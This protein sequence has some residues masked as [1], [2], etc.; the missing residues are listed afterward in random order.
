M[1]TTTILR[2]AR[3]RNEASTG[4]ADLAKQRAKPVCE[5]PG[6]LIDIQSPYFVSFI[7]LSSAL[8]EMM[9]GYP[10]SEEVAITNG[11]WRLIEENN[12]PFSVAKVF[13]DEKRASSRRRYYTN[14]LILDSVV[15]ECAM[16][17]KNRLRREPLYGR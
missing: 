11:I 2:E 16:E 4:I 5:Q 13:A 1:G 7:V 14:R 8:K 17:T 3:D 6:S 12:I 9:G 15:G 10:L